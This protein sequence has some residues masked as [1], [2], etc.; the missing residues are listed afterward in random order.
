MLATLPWN[1]LICGRSRLLTFAI[2][3]EARSMARGISVDMRAVQQGMKLSDPA[4]R[5][6][7]TMPITPIAVPENVKDIRFVPSPCLLIVS[8]ALRLQLSP[9]PQY[10]ALRPPHEGEVPVQFQTC[11]FQFASGRLK[12]EA[13]LVGVCH[14]TPPFL[15]LKDIKT[16]FSS[17]AGRRAALAGVVGGHGA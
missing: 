15:T 4:P 14:Y 11:Q 16:L 7:T 13:E 12:S 5:S 17:P 8:E 2:L 1:Y 9:Y 10:V 6:V 3:I